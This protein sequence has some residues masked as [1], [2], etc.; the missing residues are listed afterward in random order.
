MKLTLLNRL[1]RAS[2]AIT[3]QG[4]RSTRATA[5]MAARLPV[6]TEKRRMTT[7]AVEHLVLLN[8][9]TNEC[10]HIG[11]DTWGQVWTCS[12]LPRTVSRQSVHNSGLKRIWCDWPFA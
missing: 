12:C 8:Y 6:A 9:K 3:R 1:V 4:S 10:W 7:W 5:T 11:A 2:L